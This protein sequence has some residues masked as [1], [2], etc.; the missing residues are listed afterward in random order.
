M[1]EISNDSFNIMV[2]AGFNGAEKYTYES[3]VIGLA[4][5]LQSPEA[6]K[7]NV[8]I[9]NGDLL[10]D[11]PLNRGGALNQDKLWVVVDG[12]KNLEAA[13]AVVKPSMERLLA[14]LPET[15]FLYV[16]GWADLRNVIDIKQK[17]L[18]ALAGNHPEDAIVNYLEEAHEEYDAKRD[19]V[20]MLQHA[21]SGLKTRMV[22]EQ[23]LE[24]RM[25]LGAELSK[26][27]VNL[28][29][30]MEEKAE[31]KY[32]ISLFNLLYD[33]AFSRISKDTITEMLAENKEKIQ[34]ANDRLDHAETGSR[35]FAKLSLEVKTLGNTRR[36]LMRRL[37]ESVD[38]ETAAVS[39][40]KFGSSFR[41]VGN[42]PL[43]KMVND[44]ISEIAKQYMSILK[45]AF[46]RKRKVT[47]QT[48][49][50]QVYE[51]KSGR[52][53]FN[54]IVTDGLRIGS[55]SYAASGNTDLVKRAFVVLTN[56]GG[57]TAAKVDSAP[58]NVVI[59]GKKLFTSFALD[60]WKDQSNTIV[61]TLAKGPFFS[62]EEATKL[63]LAGIS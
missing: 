8:F 3:G 37:K 4:H 54:L 13:A 49:K 63:Y 7:P 21:V 32:R 53:E 61:A 24:T 25:K 6:K 30:G 5:L 28:R 9:I 12:V 41:F 42:I 39:M 31:V 35:E 17:Y 59:G 20:V 14:A 15:Q 16:T 34:T 55:G 46:G 60:P 48:D 22:D 40:R 52:Y 23:D 62:T 19:A 36:K 33:C 29:L 1:A 10:P 45:D 44:V 38:G 18:R 51:K 43:P 11:M 50:L 2:V 47:I 26:A 57:E 56:L 27:R 58:L